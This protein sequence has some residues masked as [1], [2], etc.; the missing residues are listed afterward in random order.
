MK[1]TTQDFAQHI[2]DAARILKMKL[3][4]NGHQEIDGHYLKNVTI[5]EV[6]N[7][8]ETL[9]IGRLCTNSIKINMYNP[10]DILFVNSLVEVKIGLEMND[11]IEWVSM[12]SFVLSEVNK[13]NAYE[14][15][16]EGYDMSTLLNVDYQPQIAYP[17]LLKDVVDD[18]C[19]Q[20][21]ITLSQTQFEKIMIDKPMEVSCKEMLC[22]MASLMGQNI[23][24][25]R[26]NQLEFFWYQDMNYMID[27][28]L[29]YLDSYKKTNDILTISSLTSGSE[30][31]TI[32][33]GSGYGI[34]FANPYM[35]QER[36]ESL[37]EKINGFTYLPCTFKWRGDPRVEVCDLLKVDNQNVIIMDHTMTFDG[38]LCSEIECQGQNEKEVV[39]A[40]S[41]TDIKLKKIY[42][43][44]QQS[45][46]DITE[47]ILG[48]QGGYYH[49]DMDENNYPIGWTIMNTPTLRDDTHLWRMS[50][51]GFGYSEDGG[52]TFENIAFDLD[53]NFSANALNTG[54]LKG[55]EFELDLETG[56]IVIGE[57]DSQGQITHP[58]FSYDKN[59]GLY[60]EA[61]S[62]IENEMKLIQNTIHVSLITNFVN[63]QT[64]DEQPHHYYPDYTQTPLKITAVVKDTL[65][66][67]IANASIIW[68]RKGQKDKDYGD[69]IL[70]E[71]AN[72]EVLTI[73]HNLEESVEYVAYATVKTIDQVELHAEGQIT[74]N[75]NTLNETKIV[76]EM[77]SIEAS[78][79][80]FVE[81][82]NNYSPGNISLTPHFFNCHYDLWS[83]STDLGISYTNIEP[84][85]SSLD[86]DNPHLHETN[87]KGLIFNDDTKELMIIPEC[88]CFDL[89][90][91]IVF[92]LKGDVE[93]AND[94]IAITKESDIATQVHQ[95]ITD[96]NELSKQYNTVIQ[97]LNS[98]NGTITSKVENIESQYNGSIEEINKKLT[99]VIQTSESIEEQYQ[100]LKEIIDENGSDLQTIT[101]Y[102][103]KTAKGIEVGELEANV[104]TLMAT[105]YFAILFND[106]E[107]MKL[108]QNLLTIERIKALSVFQLGNVIFTSKDYG[109]DI[110]WG[111]E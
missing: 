20:C 78:S 8:L 108:E 25:N 56:A 61:M 34:T 94:T 73:Q 5:H 35:T 26:E 6:S 67:T 70:G 1:K 36:L 104:K 79:H 29:I 74:I 87:I 52:K 39:M 2:H 31:E 17:A 110:T 60:I 95:I 18:I 9:S 38:G 111:G 10:G 24:M 97:E 47:N 4:F 82:E 69:L 66:E 37:L 30:E 28:S 91:V 48:H 3:I 100:T 57:R 7:G 90:H 84:L 85:T 23:R 92:K 105:S 86:E 63:N 83:L 13:E 27:E 106:E 16:I 15:S 33:C 101:T 88:V 54:I 11:Q 59:K 42:H 55:D 62:E 72:N 77:C 102:I 53:G 43:T 41:P 109:F 99:S 58:V 12:G 21:H 89:S 98:V 49:I 80:A 71:N 68:K 81:E 64:Y 40:Q 46:K 44:L 51:G 75:L 96:M 22:Y 19:Q 107:V 32:T 14:V 93:N 50:M 45:Y 65:Q 103:R 76:G